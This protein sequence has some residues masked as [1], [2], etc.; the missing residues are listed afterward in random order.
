MKKYLFIFYLVQEWANCNRREMI[1]EMAKALPEADFVCINRPADLIVSPLINR[2]RISGVLNRQKRVCAVAENVT[3]L[4]PIYLAHEQL[5]RG[6]LSWSNMWLLEI[7][8]A[9]WIK[10]RD[11]YER[12]FQ[13]VYEPF[14]SPLTRFLPNSHLI[15]ELFDEI[16][17]TPWDSLE[18]LISKSEPVVLERADLILALTQRIADRRRKYSSKLVVIGNGLDF[19]L[20]SKAVMVQERPVELRGIPGPIIG[21]SGNI[22]NWIDFNLL[23]QVM[24]ARPDWSFVLVGPVE[25][26][27][28][29]KLKSL[30]QQNLYLLGKKQHED[31]YKYMAYIDVGIIPYLQSEFIRCSRPLKMLEFLAAGVPVVTVPVDVGSLNEI[32]GAISFACTPAEFVEKIQT[33]IE[34]GKLTNR[35]TC[36]AFA[37]QN[38]W[39]RI[40]LKVLNEFKNRWGISHAV[41]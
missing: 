15:Y 40:V 33:L 26:N 20:F 37:R 27:V 24:A 1:L 39:D 14:F 41:E 23:H 36:Q 12:I 17:L 19:N 6:W 10:N 2:G 11:R 28:I 4:R 31:L 16:A 30:P 35:E 34:A 5:A 7:Q 25:K 21:I 8:L 13:W 22:R 29:P 32:E 38:S 3:L 9:P 18:P